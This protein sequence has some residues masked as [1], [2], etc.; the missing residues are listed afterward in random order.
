MNPHSLPPELMDMEN[1]LHARPAD[2]PSPGLRARVLQAA[3]SATPSS[4]QWNAWAWAS[5]AAALL[6][7][8]NLSMISA[9]QTEFSIRP[10]RGPDQF[11]TE[12]QTLQQL[13]AQQEGVLK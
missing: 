13:E 1:R 4:S 9:S 3:A 6:V 5:I 10:A 2:Q 11:T 7:A 12:L 8:V